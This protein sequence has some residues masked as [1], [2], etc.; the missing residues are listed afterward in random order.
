MQRRIIT[1]QR[2]GI[3]VRVWRAYGKRMYAAQA[4]VCGT[5]V[6]LT[7]GCAP[8]CVQDMTRANVKMKRREKNGA[9]YVYYP[10]AI[11]CCFYVVVCKQCIPM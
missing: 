2:L 11:L 10:P 4:H 8:L 3:F 9:L 6:C 7:L 1:H 5:R